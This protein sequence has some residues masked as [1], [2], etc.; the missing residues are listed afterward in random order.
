MGLEPATFSTS[1][2]VHARIVECWCAI[3]SGRI[4]SGTVLT[5]QRDPSRSG[6][7]R[8]RIITS[9]VALKI[10]IFE[11][12]FTCVLIASRLVAEPVLREGLGISCSGRF[13]AVPARHSGSVNGRFR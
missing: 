11:A 4:G 7:S 13:G 10:S 12:D 8:N 6:H 2:H 5:D 9:E 1:W 3:F